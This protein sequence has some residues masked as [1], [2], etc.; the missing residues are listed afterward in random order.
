MRSSVFWRT[1]GGYLLVILVVVAAV[2]LFAL[3][4]VRERHIA[5]LTR[6]LERQAV[7]SAELAGPVLADSQP[8]RL[9]SLVEHLGEE[10]GT[11]V[12][13]V[14]TLGIVLGDSEE[15]PAKMENHG[16]RPE[17]IQAR[18]GNTGSSTRF[19]RTVEREMLYVA[20]PMRAGDRVVA[21]MRISLFL[22]DVN[23]LLS[24]LGR[25]IVLVAA[26]LVVLALLAAV[27]FAWS[28]S[29]PVQKLADAAH[30]VGDGDFEVRVSSRR[31]DEFGDL[32]DRFNDMVARL[33]SLVRAQ[34]S[35]AEALGIIINSINEGL[36]V[37]DSRGRIR[38]ANRSFVQ[39]AGEE[40]LE[41]REYW[42]VVRDSNLGGLV[43]STG[44]ERPTG[45]AEVSFRQ[46]RFICSAGYVESAEETVVT[47]HDITEIARMAQMKRDLVV[48]VSH[49]LRTPLTA[50]KGFVETME[51]TESDENR[52]YLKIIGRHTERLINI[53][54]DLLV[55]SELEE[56]DLEPK[57]RPVD[58][59]GLVE[60]VLKTFERRVAEK[61]LDLELE[62]E[63]GVGT[64]EADAF[65]LDQVFINLIDNAVKY[66]DSGCVKVTISRHNGGVKIDV[67]DTGIGIPKHQLSRV[68]ERFYVTDKARSRKLGG[69][70]LGLSIVKH[71]VLLHGGSIEVESEPG[72]GTVFTVFLPVAT[73]G[74]A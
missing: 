72:R 34:T 42:D 36:L 49:E 55:L 17:I 9:Q 58:L 57:T 20:V 10:T 51:E 33:R 64:V 14:D 70:G 40:K 30:R 13:V 18:R 74:P 50:I 3:G 47:F 59:G 45:S 32:T 63:P 46:R 28:V 69:T 6:D 19:S 1:F 44:R 53:V 16:A 7:V 5:T 39:L 29:R 26:V 11:R 43:K 48:N 65:K 61:G 23:A 2:L 24:Q 66:T 12:T 15:D 27:V 71:I 22:S 38:L 73:P 56:R 37:L 60:N 54:K 21:V 4:T 25:E 8:A 41:G 52:R 31:S 68:F 67:A 62:I 35:Q